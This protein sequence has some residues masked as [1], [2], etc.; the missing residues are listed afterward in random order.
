[1]YRKKTILGLIPARGGSKGLPGKNIRPLLGKPLLAWT[2]ETA[3]KSRYLDRI[4]LSSDD[5]EIITVAKRWGCEVPFVRP[6]SI[7]GDD[8]PG[9]NPVVHAIKNVF[10]KYDYIVML[11]PT[12]PLR[13]VD[14]IDGCIQQCVIGKYKSCVSVTEADQSPFWMY[15]VAKSSVMRPLLKTKRRIV[16]RQDLPAIHCLNGAV[17]VANCRWLLRTKSFLAGKVSAYEMPTERSLD[18]DTELD[19][20]KVKAVLQARQA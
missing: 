11:Q 5:A 6:K 7:S 14:D 16:R 17:Y 10:P 1:M 3:K 2:I 20:L 19:F 4:I 15:K 13:S 12:S 18:I 9:I 8:T